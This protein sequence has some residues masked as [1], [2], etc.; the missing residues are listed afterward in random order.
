MNFIVYRLEPSKT[1]PGKTEKIPV[2]HRTGH[3]HSPMDPAIWTTQAQATAAA[4]AFGPAHGVGL[5]VTPGLWFLDIDNCLQADNTWSPLALELCQRLAGAYVEVSASGKGLHLIG[6]GVLPP[7]GTRNGA[8]GLE[9]YTGGRFCAL[10]GTNCLGD[11]AAEIPAIQTVAAQ[12]FPAG[13]AATP[14]DWTDGPC[15][16]WSGPVDDDVLIAKMLEARSAASV[17]GGKPSVRQLWEADETA[18]GQSF[19]DAN[20]RAYDASAADAALAQHLAFWTGKDCT[21]IDRL[22]RRSALVRDK[23]ERADYMFR[24]ITRA[25]GQQR[26]VLGARQAA[27]AAAGEGASGSPVAGE[28]AAVRG[29]QSLMPGLIHASDYAAHFDGCVYIEDRYAAA[30]PDGSILSP[31][32]FRANGRYG[33][34]RFMMDDQKVSRNAWEAFAESELWRPPFAHGLC[35]R[36]ELPPRSLTVDAGRVLFNSYVPAQVVAA[37]GD[38]TPLLRHLALL[39]PNERDRQWLLAWM[40]RVVQSPGEKLQWAPLIQ[41][42]E[43]NGKSLLI[44]V[45]VYCVGERYSHIPNA[46]DLSNKFNP[47]IEG[48]L[49][50]GVEEIY[51]SDR[52]DVLDMLK[53]LITNRRIEIQAKGQNQVTGDNRVNFMLTS[54]HRDAVAKTENDRR[55]AVFYTDQ[56]ESADLARCGMVGNYFPTFYG[57]WRKPEAKAAVAHFLRTMAIAEEMDPAGLAHRAP[58]T[59]STSAAIEE[60]LGPIEQAIVEAVA[61]GDTGFRGGWVSSFYLNELLERRRLRNRCPPNHWD[62]IVTSLGYVKHPALS[63]GRTNNEVAPEGRKSRLWVKKDSIAALNLTTPTAAAAAYTA[64]NSGLGAPTAATA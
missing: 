9:L 15:E 58:V 8:L 63:K 51:I 16:G 40:A 7:H 52:R 55:Y 18:L 48:K 1:R 6:R 43:G 41:G 32:Q 50:A 19:P 60:G 54:N 49:F 27:A 30:V 2:D 34:H 28:L 39:I 13:Q 37:P 23:W 46:Q 17:F 42:C 22:M 36:P 47:W 5:I 29:D 14:A 44:D 64:A 38:V 3:T 62:R 45:M 12:Y 35:F 31:Q 61:S 25:C 20:G 53:V 10:T 24:T 56:Q 21:R 57:W 33:G 26:E 11:M 4:V 59:S